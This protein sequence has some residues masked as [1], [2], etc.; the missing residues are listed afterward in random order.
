M[1]KVRF[2]RALG[3]GARHAAKSLLEAAD[4][5][6]S[7]D[8]RPKAAAPS[9]TT[10]Q[11]AGSRA[12]E[13]HRNTVSTAHQARKAAKAS[14]KSLLDPVKTFSGTLWLQVTG[15]FFTLFAVFLAQA[16]WNLRSAAHSHADPGL[17]HKLYAYVALAF[18]F[19][20]F[21]VTSFVR[22]SR[23]GKRR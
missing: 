7:P 4:A 22:A 1:D 5:A 3:K 10:A 18:V 14:R 13:I 15:T 2:G 8:P 20:Y 19:A 6:A 17:T 11:A 12:A 23:R 9:R 16:S 21:A